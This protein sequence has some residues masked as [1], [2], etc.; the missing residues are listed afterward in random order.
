MDST[1]PLL[2]SPPKKGNKT[3]FIMLV[4]VLGKNIILHDLTNLTW[5]SRIGLL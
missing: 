2:V 4:V 5:P 1:T 3:T